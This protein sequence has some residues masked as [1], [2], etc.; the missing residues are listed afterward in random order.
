METNIRKSIINH[1]GFNMDVVVSSNVV[2]FIVT[3][4]FNHN[5][6]DLLI[7]SS[8]SDGFDIDIDRL[9]VEYMGINDVSAIGLVYDEWSIIYVKYQDEKH[10]V[11]WTPRQKDAWGVTL[12][13]RRYLCVDHITPGWFACGYGSEDI[14]GWH[15]RIDR[16]KYT[17][18]DGEIIKTRTG[19]RYL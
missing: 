15:S 5:I 1:N 18:K 19:W 12:I 10:L 17:Y 6:P 14:M 9:E 13:N 4:V 3:E 11:V 8:D 7:Y 2:S 16:I